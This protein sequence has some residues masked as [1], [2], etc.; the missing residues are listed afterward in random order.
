MHARWQ[1]EEGDGEDSNSGDGSDC[2]VASHVAH[3]NEHGAGDRRTADCDSRD[4]DQ[5]EWVD[6]GRPAA[7][8]NDRSPTDRD[9][10]P[11]VPGIYREVWVAARRLCDLGQH[12]RKREP[13]R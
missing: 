12:V 5:G 3:C 9:E 7:R 13:E 11:R 8:I 2:S 6:V 4:A 10:C 1:N